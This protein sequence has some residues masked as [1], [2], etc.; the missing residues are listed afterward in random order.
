MVER[1]EP[2]TEIWEMKIAEKMVRKKQ[3]KAPDHRSGAFFE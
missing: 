1:K 2:P 3:K